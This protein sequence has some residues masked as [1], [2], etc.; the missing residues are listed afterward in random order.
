MCRGWLGLVWN[1]EGVWS[2]RERGTRKG[3]DIL[4]R[5]ILPLTPLMFK[6]ANRELQA[7]TIVNFKCHAFHNVKNSS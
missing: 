1:C 2:H 3:K 5:G 6:R 4:S 7:A